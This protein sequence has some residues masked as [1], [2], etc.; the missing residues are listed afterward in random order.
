VAIRVWHFILNGY[1]ILSIQRR[2]QQAHVR[3]DRDWM[4]CKT[5]G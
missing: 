1:G 3:V 5:G 4:R 2:R